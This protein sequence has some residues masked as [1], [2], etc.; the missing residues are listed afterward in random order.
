MA[1]G[2]PIIAGYIFRNNLHSLFLL[3]TMFSL[4]GLIGWQM[5]ELQGVLWILIL[6]IVLLIGFPRFSSQKI[7]NACSAEKVNYI[8]NP[9]LL[10]KIQQLSENAGLAKLPEIYC[11]Q[12]NSINCFTMQAGDT[13]V[14][15]VSKALINNLDHAETKAVLAHEVAHIYQDDINV[16]LLADKLSHFT[17]SLSA[18]GLIML[19]I[20]PIL[21]MQNIAVPW[22]LIISL[23]LAHYLTALLQLSLSRTREFCADVIAVQLTNDVEAMVSALK[24]IEQQPRHWFDDMLIYKRQ[25]APSLLRSHPSTQ[26]RVFSLLGLDMLSNFGH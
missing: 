16:M 5:S 3:L 25:R 10:L 26:D 19:S 15:V 21:S 12:E 22:Q 11:S 1:V 7:L 23:L 9:Q 4:L 6:G 14:I 8:E 17:Q 20:A 13:N 18:V 2:S 24:K